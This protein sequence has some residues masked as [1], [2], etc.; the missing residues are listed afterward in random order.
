[1]N[2]TKC[3]KCGNSTDLSK[4]SCHSCG[5]IFSK[6]YKSR[7]TKSKEDAF[8]K[9]GRGRLSLLVDIVLGILGVAMIL[10]GFVIL[11]VTGS[12]NGGKA[13]LGET[14]CLVFGSGI[15]VTGIL[16]V[17]FSAYGI[18]REIK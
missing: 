14:S 16:C 13:L 18:A 9:T 15:F 10:S 4:E 3:P 12:T 5:V 6:F 8:E 1:M 11:F 2:L 17:I 7:L